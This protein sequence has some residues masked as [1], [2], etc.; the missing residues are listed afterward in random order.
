[1]VSTLTVANV[2]YWSSGDSSE[3]EVTDEFFQ[4]FPE[5]PLSSTVSKNTRKNDRS[6]FSFKRCDGPI[7]SHCASTRANHVHYSAVQVTFCGIS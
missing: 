1:M 2:W 7:L 5:C 6:P 3:I 4:T